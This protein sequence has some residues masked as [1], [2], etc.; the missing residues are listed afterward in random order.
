RRSVSSFKASQGAQHL[1]AGPA[2]RHRGEQ[3]NLGM[4]NTEVRLEDHVLRC[5]DSRIDVRLSSYAAEGAGA[6]SVGNTSG[7]SAQARGFTIFA[8]SFDTDNVVAYSV[9]RA[10]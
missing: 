6:R 9:G 5:S 2:D 4:D 8:G 7:W 3:R 10:S 1:H